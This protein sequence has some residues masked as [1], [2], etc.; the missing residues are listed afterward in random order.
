MKANPGV[1]EQVDQVRDSSTPGVRW[2]IVK[3]E[4]EFA[5]N[6]FGSVSGIKTVHGTLWAE[7]GETVSLYIGYT[8]I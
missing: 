4:N 1:G 5:R 8:I 6:Y 3:L 2:R 7:V